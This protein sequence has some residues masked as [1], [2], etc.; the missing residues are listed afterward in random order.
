MAA[1]CRSSAAADWCLS[2]A[3]R[4]AAAPRATASAAFWPSAARPRTGAARLRLLPAPALL[5]LSSTPLSPSLAVWRRRSF[6]A[7]RREGCLS[8]ATAP[9]CSF[10]SAKRLSR[11]ALSAATV[12]SAAA[13]ASSIGLRAGAEGSEPARGPALLFGGDARSLAAGPPG[14][15]SD[16]NIASLARLERGEDGTVETPEADAQSP[17][18]SRVRLVRGLRLLQ[19]VYEEKPNAVA[20]SVCHTEGKQRTREFKR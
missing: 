10:V 1:A 12:A 17:A 18:L 5:A 3:S 6:L 15:P 16:A 20:Q 8:R 9:S 19:P 7:S 2:A 11:S 4:E 14:R 13:M